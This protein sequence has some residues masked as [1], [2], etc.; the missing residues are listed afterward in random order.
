M[1]AVK[2][3]PAPNT[4]V[5]SGY[6]V[7]PFQTTWYT[8]V[9]F[10]AELTALR[11]LKPVGKATVRPPVPSCVK[12]KVSC[13]PFV[14]HPES[15]EEVIFVVKDVE[16]TNVTLVPVVALGQVNVGVALNVVVT[17]A[18]ALPD[19]VLMVAHAEPVQ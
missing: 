17:I 9:L 2:A 1:G 15:V 4:V 16:S 18:A 3:S 14:P 12:M 8:V 13:C 6:A 7:V 11:L 19:P 10:A 5:D